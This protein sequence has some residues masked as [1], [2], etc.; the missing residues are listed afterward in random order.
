MG[1]RVRLRIKEVLEERQMTQ[2]E[3]SVLSG[4][5]PAAISAL[6]RGNIERVSLSHLEKI[7]T[8]L[9]IDDANELFAFEYTV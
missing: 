3:L 2:G 9:D 7:A 5:R 8:A 1:V 6:T 4:V